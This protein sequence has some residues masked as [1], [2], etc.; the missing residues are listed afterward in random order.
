M[1]TFRKDV[2]GEELKPGVYVAYN[3][4]GDVAKGQLVHAGRGGHGPYK[5][6]LLH[7][8]AG[9]PSGHISNV[10]RSYAMLVVSENA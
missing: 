6:R 5:V 2:R 4:S 9:H 10:K 8:A 3:L 7:K 1:I